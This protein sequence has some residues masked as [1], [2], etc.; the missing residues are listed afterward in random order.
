MDTTRVKELAETIKSSE[1]MA[2]LTGAGISVA[3]G[4]PDFRSKDGLWTKYDPNIYAS[5]QQFMK[6]PSYFWEMHIDIIHLLRAA[7]PNPAHK[8]LAVLEDKGKIHGIIT[9]NIDGLHQRA[10][11]TVVHELH[12]TNETCSCILCGNHYET[13]TLFDHLLSF[14]KGALVQLMRNKKEIPTCECGGWIKPDIILFGEMM[15]SKPLKAAEA[16]AISCTLLLVV[17]TS[18]QVQPAASIP[19][20][21]KKTGSLIG[22]IN[23]EPGPLDWMADCV[24]IGTAEE[25]LPHVLTLL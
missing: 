4:I 22:I 14:E 17:G 1:K 21:A 12:G 7:E 20:V 16:L 2:V 18:L 8:A 15:P 19:F 25:I 13:R 24:V 9:Q 6:D 10:G 5:Y 3:S 11:S 23:D